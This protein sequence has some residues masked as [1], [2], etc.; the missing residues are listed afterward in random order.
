M[1]LHKVYTCKS[2]IKARVGIPDLVLV[3][4][5]SKHGISSRNRLREFYSSIKEFDKR[6]TKNDF[7]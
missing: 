1:K 4:Y 7:T 2:G 6:V 5:F 3:M